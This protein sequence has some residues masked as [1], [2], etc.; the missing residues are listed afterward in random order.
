MIIDDT[1]DP[2]WA[3]YALLIGKAMACARDSEKSG[4][5]SESGARLCM[6]AANHLNHEYW[7]SIVLVKIHTSAYVKDKD[8][9]KWQ[10]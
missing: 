8:D 4:D 5:L 7:P 1:D 2:T 6:N 9:N 10:N 3:A